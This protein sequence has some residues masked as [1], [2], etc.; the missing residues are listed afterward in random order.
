MKVVWVL[1]LVTGYGV[2]IRSTP[3]PSAAT[4]R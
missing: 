1:L 3:N 4:I 2:D